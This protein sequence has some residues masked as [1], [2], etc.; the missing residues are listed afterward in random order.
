MNIE[1]QST[2]L[3]SANPRQDAQFYVQYFG[4]KAVAELSWFVSLQH[5]QLPHLFLDFIDFHHAST[6]ESQRGQLASG[7]LLALIVADVNT[8]AQRLREQGLRLIKEPTDEPWG[9]RRFQV[10]APNGV[11]VEVLQRIP[12]DAA[13]LK[14]EF[15]A[16][17]E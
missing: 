16:S 5:S 13:W 7:V 3:M 14:K 4:F 15:A 2:V 10:A 1:S 9:Q 17:Q 11:V 8:E 12:P 6:A